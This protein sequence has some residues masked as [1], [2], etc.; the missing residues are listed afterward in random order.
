MLRFPNH[1][2]VFQD[3]ILIKWFMTSFTGTNWSHSRI[4]WTAHSW[5][6]FADILKSGDPKLSCF[7]FDQALDILATFKREAESWEENECNHLWNSSGI[8]MKKA[9]WCD[10]VFSKL[11]L[12]TDVQLKKL[13]FSA[14]LQEEPEAL[15]EVDLFTKS[16]LFDVSFTHG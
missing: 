2:T 14:N 11:F 4:C 12:Q 1:C 13:W 6:E 5:K 7:K 9:I 15:W 10:R 3:C 8:F 16:L